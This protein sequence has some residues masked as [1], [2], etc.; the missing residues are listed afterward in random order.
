[1]K[2]RLLYLPVTLLLSL[3]LFAADNNTDSN[4]DKAM[5]AYRGSNFKDA[6]PGFKQAIKNKQDIKLNQTRLAQCLAAQA[7]EQQNKSKFDKA[8]ALFLEGDRFTQLSDDDKQIIAVAGEGFGDTVMFARLLQLLNIDRKKNG[9]PEVALHLNGIQRLLLPMLQ[10]SAVAS[11]ITIGD[12]KRDKNQTIIPLIGVV[13]PKHMFEGKHTKP[14]LVPRQD[15]VDQWK[16]ELAKHPGRLNVA[17]AWISG[18]DRN[19]NPVPVLGGRILDRDLPVK[20]VIDIARAADPNAH[21]YLVQGPPHH[22]IVLQSD[23]DKM[24]ADDKRKYN[25]NVIPDEYKNYVTHVLLPDGSE[26]DGA[27]EKILALLS[28]CIYVGSD[29]VTPHISGNLE[30]GQA[31]MVLPA[32]KDG[33]SGRDWRWATVKTVAQAEGETAWY[34]ADK[35]R[36][37]EV[38]PHD[39]Q[40]VA[41]VVALLKQ[42]HTARQ[43]QQSK[44]VPTTDCSSC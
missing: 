32:A 29:T 34:P 42:W 38:N 5:E 3:Q 26:P 18:R 10:R 8:S 7:I 24:S 22:N 27:F 36:M 23:Y 12:I 28:Q 15:L 43:A 1:M 44:V 35:V 41:P 31:I 30:G 2:H 19:N 37:L 14:Y 11:T 40:A 9:L 16:T 21:V 17:T 33:V 39:A 20:T 6:A 13:N 25:Y 4:L